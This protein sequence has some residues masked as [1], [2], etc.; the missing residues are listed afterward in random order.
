M[1]A[2]GVTLYTAIEGV[3]PFDSAVEPM[4]LMDSV[5]F[6]LPEPATHA[7]PLRALL[8]GLLDKDPVR[9]LDLTQARA[10]LQAVS[11]SASA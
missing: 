2:L 11:T 8:D 7:G 9:R 3:P 10:C 4:E 6:E 1:Y 5:L